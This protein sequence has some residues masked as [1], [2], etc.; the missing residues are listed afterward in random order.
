M[1]GVVHLRSTMGNIF[2]KWYLGDFTGAVLSFRSMLAKSR[3]FKVISSAVIPT[4][5]LNF[6]VALPSTSSSK[7][8]LRV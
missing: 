5:S 1:M 6:L 3:L 7:S 8:Y 2:A 4:L